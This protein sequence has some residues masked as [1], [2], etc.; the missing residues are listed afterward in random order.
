MDA[1]AT[2]DFEVVERGVG[3]APWAKASENAGKIGR[4]AEASGRR[5]SAYGWSMA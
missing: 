5:V 1:L 2:S 4:A 3:M